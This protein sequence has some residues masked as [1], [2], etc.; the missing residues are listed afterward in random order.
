MEACIDIHVWARQF[1]KMGHQVKL[2][3]PQYIKPFVRVNKNDQLDAAANAATGN[4][5]RD[6]L[7]D[8]GVVIP[9]SD[10]A[11]KPVLLEDAEHPISHRGRLLLDNLRSQWL[12]K[13]RI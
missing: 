12:E 1:V 7:A 3:A 2:L 13:K 6:L 11:I 5:I 4:E 9:N 10:A 8:M